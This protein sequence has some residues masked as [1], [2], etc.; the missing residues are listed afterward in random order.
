MKEYFPKVFLLIKYK[1]FG[2]NPTPP[3]LF[4]MISYTAYT[5]LYYILIARCWLLFISYHFLTISMKPPTYSR[6][7]RY[8]AYSRY[9]RYSLT[10]LTQLTI[11][12]YYFI[13]IYIY[14]Y[15]WTQTHVYI[16]TN[17]R[18]RE[19]KKERKSAWKQAPHPHINVRMFFKKKPARKQAPQP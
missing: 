17:Y 9:S 7:S 2:G 8:F 3:T 11:Y 4:Y 15:I 5:L 10:S 13:C 14:I 18:D 12:I 6:Y 19:R 16:C 1:K